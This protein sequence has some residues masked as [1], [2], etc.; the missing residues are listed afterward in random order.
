MVQSRW[1][2]IGFAQQIALGPALAQVAATAGR[3]P[4]AL[5]QSPAAGS[6]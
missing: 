4:P 1:N 2:L 6:R 5:Q 3:A